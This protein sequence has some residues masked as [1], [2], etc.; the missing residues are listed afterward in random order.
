MNP[1][2][3]HDAHR[4]TDHP[5]EEEL[6][7]PH[8]LAVK[9]GRRAQNRLHLVR[10]VQEHAAEDFRRLRVALKLKGRDDAKVDTPAADSPEQL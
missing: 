1:M 2:Y 6:L 10:G 4:G 7:G 8:L 3:T 9:L 5:G